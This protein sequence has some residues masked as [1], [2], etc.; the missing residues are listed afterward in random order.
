MQ[1]SDDQC[2]LCMEGGSLSASLLIGV[3]TGR[4][5]CLS[6]RW[7]SPQPRCNVRPFPR[8]E[9]I[10]NHTFPAVQMKRHRSATYSSWQISPSEAIINL[11]MRFTLNGQWSYAAYFMLFLPRS[12]SNL[13][14]LHTESRSNHS[15]SAWRCIN[16]GEADTRDEVS[17]LQ[18]R[19]SLYAKGHS[20]VSFWQ[21]THN[22]YEGT[23]YSILHQLTAQNSSGS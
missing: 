9:T 14:P 1:N 17:A 12:Q 3:T 20:K 6:T 22:Q 5:V 23:V 19:R 10:W 8:H 15:I 2:V 16:N 13:L 18:Y 4:S 7:Q 11:D 21:N